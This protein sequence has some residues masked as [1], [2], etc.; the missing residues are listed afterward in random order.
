MF[1]QKISINFIESSCVK[2]TFPT[3]STYFS[4]R[5]LDDIKFAMKPMLPHDLLFARIATAKFT[6]HYIF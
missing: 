5:I 6:N 4:L 1:S 2:V 3:C